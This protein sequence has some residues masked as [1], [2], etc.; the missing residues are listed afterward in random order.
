M[1]TKVSSPDHR[2]VPDPTIAEAY[3][4]SGRAWAEGPMRVY[5]RLAEMVV[6]LCPVALADQ[7]VL[8][9][10]AGTGAAS[11]AIAIAG[12]RPVAVDNA[13]GMLAAGRSRS[14]LGGE[15]PVPAGV[16]DALALPFAGGAFHAVIA[17]FS[18][19]HVEDLAGA[20]REAGRVTR[21]GGAVV[22]SGYADD[23]R[24]PVKGAVVGALVEYGWV[25]P[26]WF[27]ALR[28]Q[29]IPAMATPAAART[30]AGEAGFGKAE[31]RKLQVPFD[32]LDASEL[33]AW[34][35]GM[36]QCAPF[37]AGLDRKRRSGVRM[38]ALDLLGSDFPPL[39]RSVV[40]LTVRI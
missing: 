6:G 3:S 22:A 19:N 4:A 25:E 39:R 15:D 29:A 38:R 12:G 23:D 7:V 30:A 32:D 9:L 21:A 5:G 16:G 36:A 13:Y 31:A 35:L 24:H 18:L 2:P 37:V 11:R 17:A 28:R 8:D 33:V 10:G 20:L 26:P 1:D 40:V 27:A 14:V 34:R